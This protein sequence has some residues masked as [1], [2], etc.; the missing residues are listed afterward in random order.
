MGG[1]SRPV[2]EWLSSGAMFQACRLPSVAGHGHGSSFGSS[3]AA[4]LWLRFTC[5]GACRRRGWL[6]CY[7]LLQEGAQCREQIRAVEGAL[8]QY[9]QD[10]AVEIE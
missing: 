7:G 8:R 5:C 4:S 6:L 10:V 1:P 3:R 9:C 2:Q